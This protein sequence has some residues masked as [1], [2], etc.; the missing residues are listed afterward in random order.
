LSAAAR[1][2]Y[3]ADR[4]AVLDKPSGL[5]L[6][7]PRSEPGA[8]VARLIAALPAAERAPLEGRSPLLVHRLDLATS[9]LVLV[10]L[11]ADTH[12]DLA[13]RFA[14]RRVEKI[15]LALVWGRPRPRAGSWTQ[16]LGPDRRDRRRMRVDPEGR[17]A[18]SD[19]MVVDAARGVALVAL[20]ARTGRTHQLRVHLAAAGHA[21]VG[22][23]LY[24]GPRHRGVREP[25]LAAALDP[26]RCLLHAWR[27][28]LPGLEPSRFEAPPPADLTAA[29]AAAGL[30]L[31][32]ARDLWQS[33][34]KP[35][36]SLPLSRLFPP[37]S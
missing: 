16:P 12:R 33:P 8:A 4:F 34:A 28:E 17:P 15:Y 2:V 35:E 32:P 5:S 9:G 29:L 30:S 22:D 6:A 24:G 25:A 3:L 13:R 1:T 27:L 19:W 36:G 37:S 21:V 10:A 7:T 11:D 26:G 20:W 18:R 23:D 31:A 14:E